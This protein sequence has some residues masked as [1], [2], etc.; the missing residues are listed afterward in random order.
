MCNLEFLEFLGSI[1]NQDGGLVWP[2]PGGFHFA[3][4]PRVRCN[5]TCKKTNTLPPRRRATCATTEKKSGHFIAPPKPSWRPLMKDISIFL[6]IYQVLL[7]G[8][9]LLYCW[10][11]VFQR[12]WTSG[13][14]DYPEVATLRTCFAAEML[15]SAIVLIRYIQSVARLPEIILIYLY[16]FVTFCVCGAHIVSTLDSARFVLKGMVAYWYD[17][18]MCIGLYQDY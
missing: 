18:L 5:L 12:L 11:A 17:S 9:T 13:A 8:M 15:P 10:W 6:S 2:A 14:F 16:L 7:K 1:L 3:R 4:S